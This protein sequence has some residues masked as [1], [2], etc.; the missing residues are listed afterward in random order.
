MTWWQR[1]GRFGRSGG[2][3]RPGRQGRQGRQ[4]HHGHGELA[5]IERR[6]LLSWQAPAIR[7]V[8]V[9]TAAGLIAGTVAAVLSAPWQLT[10]LVVW[11]NAA[12]MFLALVWATISRFTPEQTAAMSTLEDTSRRGSGVVLLCAATASLVGLAFG[13][14]RAN[15][16]HGQLRFWL[17]FAVISG[18]VLSW[19]VVHTVYVLRYAHLYYSARDAGTA[20]GVTFPGGD[21]PDYLDFAYL[22]FTLGMTFQVSDNT[23]LSR[24]LRRTVL[25]HCLMSYLFGTVII[26]TSIN[27]LAALV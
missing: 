9:A 22:A 24:P 10:V 1:F 17:T 13:L 20:H 19:A 7:R 6:L 15:Q 23:V 5:K 3:G 21:D 18:I 16:A 4:V 12:S 26:A 11:N 27:V 25:L 14:H 2:S 8:M